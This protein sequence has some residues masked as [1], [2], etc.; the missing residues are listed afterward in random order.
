MEHREIR[1]Q[2]P[3]LMKSWL[4]LC[5]WMPFSHTVG[6][7]FHLLINICVHSKTR[8]AHSQS[9]ATLKRLVPLSMDS[10]FS[11][12]FI[13]LESPAS[14][15]ELVV[16]MV[17]ESIGSKGCP[18]DIHIYW[19]PTDKYEPGSH[20]SPHLIIPSNPNCKRLTLFYPTNIQRD[21]LSAGDIAVNILSKISGLLSIVT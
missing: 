1:R 14:P 8:M 11:T 2:R 4:S 6:W 20:W 10:L 21:V 16:P 13:S 9:L 5:L 7:Y 19:K 3:H 18:K 15:Y 17:V 12:G